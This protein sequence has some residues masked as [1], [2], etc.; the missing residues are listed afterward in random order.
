LVLK[1]KKVEEAKGGT[2]IE[3][4]AKPKQPIP[5]DD[6]VKG[7]FVKTYV[8]KSPPQ[9]SLLIYTKPNAKKPG[10]FIATAYLNGKEVVYATGKDCTTSE[11]AVKFLENAELKSL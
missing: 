4:G 2:K 3:A 7:K 11:A 8:T 10:Q 5:A 6:P 1:L 9:S